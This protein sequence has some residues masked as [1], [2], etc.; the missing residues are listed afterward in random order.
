M[1]PSLE[2]HNQPMGLAPLE[3]GPNAGEEGSHA[4]L[5]ALFAEVTAL[6]NQ[7]R[8]TAALSL[9]QD[10]SP[11]AGLGILRIIEA[12][13]PQTVPRIARI[14]SLSRQNI[15]IQVNRLESQGYVVSAP[16]PAHKRSGLIC[17][18]DAGQT[19]LAT[20]S[21][22]ETNSMERLLPQVPEARLRP[23]T[24][25]LRRL[26]L[27]L[28]GNELPPEEAVA[29][30][31]EIKRAQGLPRPARSGKPASPA[32]APP[33]APASDQTDESEFPVNLL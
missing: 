2:P 29:V 1:P 4:K 22:R 5:Q 21:G 11:A 24:K 26:R 16:N 33:A 20:A 30:R 14:R 31:P 3:P 28:A 8:K 23:T 7:L 10:N 32:A 13:G 15:Q 19:L 9:R 18:T 12:L 27:L 6:A 17:L 25:L